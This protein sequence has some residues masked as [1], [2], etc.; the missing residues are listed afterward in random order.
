MY[1]WMVIAMFVVMMAA[2]NLAPRAD[3]KEQQQRPLAEAAIT[4]FL[5]QHRAAVNYTKDQIN[6]NYNNTI[7]LQ[8]GRN[9]LHICNSDGGEL[10]NYLPTGYK[11]NE[12]EYFSDVYCLTATTY[13][14]DGTVTIGGKEAAS[15]SDSLT[16]TRYVITYG[17]VPERWKNVSTNKIL[18]DF[19]LALRQQ[20]PA[21]ASCGIVGKKQT[22][23]NYYLET[24]VD[25]QG[26]T[27]ILNHNPLNSSYVIEGI[28]VHDVSIPAYF[29]KDY[30]SDFHANCQKSGDTTKLNP[31]YPCLIYITPV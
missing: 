1:V 21:G 5:V 8:Q 30:T 12:Q 17:R 26:M 31:A 2:F 7:D 11:Y 19:F 27:H 13:N 9:S 23:E 16:S 29:L 3:F 6:K 15:C 22:A 10:C 20:I 25:S 14:A 28:D 24:T 18:G 4:K